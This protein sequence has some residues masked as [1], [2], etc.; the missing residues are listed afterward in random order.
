LSEV[1]SLT[2]RI[3]DHGGESRWKAPG[4]VCQANTSSRG[5]SITLEYFSPTPRTYAETNQ[6]RRIEGRWG[7]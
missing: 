7:R 5:A 6:W 4:R 1:A 2:K 3:V